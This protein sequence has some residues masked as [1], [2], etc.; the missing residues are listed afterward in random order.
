MTGNQAHRGQQ[1]PSDLKERKG[2]KEAQSTTHVRNTVHPNNLE[3]AGQ[4]PSRSRAPRR[5]PR[6]HPA[7]PPRSRVASLP[8][9]KQIDSASLEATPRR[10]GQ[11]AIRSPARHTKALNGHNSAV[12]PGLDGVRTP[13]CIVAVTGV[14]DA[15]ND[16]VATSSLSESLSS[17]ESHSSQR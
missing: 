13:L 15:L 12:A 9:G 4:S 7:P 17:C 8:S 10:K 6:Q 11:T 16:M 14:R 3:P 2:L 5:D 1:F